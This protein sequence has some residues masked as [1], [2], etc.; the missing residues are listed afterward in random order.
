MHSQRGDD[1]VDDLLLPGVRVLVRAAEVSEQ[2]T[3]LLVIVSQ[4][5][6]GI[7][8]HGDLVG[9]WMCASAILDVAPAIRQYPSRGIGNRQCTLTRARGYTVA[10]KPCTTWSPAVGRGCTAVGRV[11][12]SGWPGPGRRHR[13]RRSGR[14]TLDAAVPDVRVGRGRGWLS[15]RPKASVHLLRVSGCSLIFP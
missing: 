10:S 5:H 4:D 13:F 2:L 7:G 15:P 8:R 11:R 14:R 12:G 9:W 6:D 3:D 1:A